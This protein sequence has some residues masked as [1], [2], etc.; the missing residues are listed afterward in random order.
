[1]DDVQQIAFC[2]S[3]QGAFVTEE[4]INLI[5]TGDD[6]IT[7][8]VW[9]QGTRELVKAE[10][11]GY[12]AKIGAPAIYV[13]YSNQADEGY[14][15]DG[16]D[17]SLGNE[18]KI[19]F[20]ISP[21]NQL[22]GFRYDFE[23]DEVWKEYPE[24][25]AHNISVHENSGLSAAFCHDGLHVFFVEPTGRLQAARLVDSD[26]VLV[27][28]PAAAS[29]SLGSA[30]NADVSEEGVNLFYI[31]EDSAL[32]YISRAH[33]SPDG[34]QDHPVDGIVFP[35]PTARFRAGRDPKNG[36]VEAYSLTEGAL[37]HFST[38]GEVLLLGQV[39]DSGQLTRVDNA[40]NIRWVI[41]NC[42]PRFHRTRLRAVYQ[43]FTTRPQGMCF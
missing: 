37:Y 43:Y 6:G 10:D 34:W 40:Q 33:G 4:E 25:D 16:E 32:R 22:I 42:R 8:E 2:L 1:M 13:R 19:I 12:G 14:A 24:I 11:V 30:L 27:D 28:F 18:E 20:A 15:G 29:A 7:E 23:E 31:G 35:S 41:R 17:T 38:N 26:W 9:G 5:H 36:Q 39:G 21:E 3:A